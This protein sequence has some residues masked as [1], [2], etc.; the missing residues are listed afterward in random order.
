MTCIYSNCENKAYF[1]YKG[2]LEPLFCW[3]HK[4]KN[5]IDVT[6]TSK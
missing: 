6:L 3:F 2:K 4:L 1:N 5:M